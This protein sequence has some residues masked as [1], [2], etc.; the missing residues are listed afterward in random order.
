MRSGWQL[1]GLLNEIVNHSV[2][3]RPRSQNKARALATSV[4][5]AFHKNGNRIG[6][7]SVVAH[8]VVG[9]MELRKHDLS[10]GTAAGVSVL[11]TEDIKA[12][13]KTMPQVDPGLSDQ[14]RIDQIRAIEELVCAGQAAQAKLSLDFDRSMREQAA[15]RGVPKERQGRGIAAQIAFARRESVHKGEQHLALAKTLPEMPYTQKAFAQGR[16]SEWKATLMLR[17]TACLSRQ[18]R[19]TV[20]REL[21]GDPERIEGMG[22]REAANEADKVAYKL[23]PRSFVERRA[24]AEKE[25]HTTLR[26]APDVMTWFTGLLPVKDGVAVHAALSAEADRLRAAGDERSRGQI[27]A[28]T[29]VQRILAPHLAGTEGKASGVP[30][31]VNVVVPDSVLWGNDNGGGWVEGYGDVPGDLIREWIAANLE[32]GVDTWLRRIYETPKTGEL[33]AMDSK[34]RGFD[35]GL[36]AFLRM[37]DRGCREKWCDA[38]VRHLD[39]A[40]G[41]AEGGLTSAENGQGLCEAHNYAKQAIGWS[42]QPRPGPR[43][44]IETTTP[45]GHTYETV[46][47]RFRP[48]TNLS[49]AEIEFVQL[50]W[51][52]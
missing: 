31:M 18:D 13:T 44:T 37:R 36:A 12:L 24:R 30:L 20:D 50:I 33:V 39:H 51:A 10:S 32:S 2:D 17:Q 19:A 41:H 6:A 40:E 43:H 21:A 16:I 48:R 27:M 3:I 42:A 52:A 35:G 49:P 11:R 26:P 7:L 23:D 14:E 47:P 46:A 5:G 8:S 9:T 34:A 25:R 1:L 28:D 22:D 45:T 4:Y 38:P 29:L 15:V